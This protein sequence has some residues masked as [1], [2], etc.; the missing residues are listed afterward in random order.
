MSGDGA[1]KVDPGADGKRAEVC[2]AKGFGGDA[3]FEA[4]GVEGSDGETGSWGDV[5]GGEAGEVEWEEGRGEA[6]NR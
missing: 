2:A 3:D 6:G 4:V 5:S 1:L